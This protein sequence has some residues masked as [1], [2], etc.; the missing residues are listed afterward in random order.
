M[1]T[2]I[3]SSCWSETR[4]IYDI[5]A[6][7]LRK[8]QNTS[9]VGRPRLRLRL[10]LERLLILL[11]HLQRRTTCPSSKPQR[12]MLPMLRPH[13]RTFSAVSFCGSLI[14]SGSDANHSRRNLPHRVEQGTRAEQREHYASSARRNHFG[15]PIR[16]RWR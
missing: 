5:C 10:L 3:L 1:R 16:Q 2:P 11:S 12:W 8:R 9:Q 6:Q 13:S 14:W 15:R 7:C 4:A